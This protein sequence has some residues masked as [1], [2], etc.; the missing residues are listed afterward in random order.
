[1]LCNQYKSSVWMTYKQAND[2]GY[3]VKSKSKGI[4]C[5]FYST[6]E[7]KG[8]EAKQGEDKELIPFIKRFTLFNADQVEGYPVTE[9]EK[10]LVNFEENE[11]AQK[12]IGNAAKEIKFTYGAG[13]C[14]YLP[15]QDTICLPDREAFTSENT[16]YATCFHEIVHGTGN[17]KRLNRS[18]GGQYGS[19]EYAFE[20][21][22]AELGAAYLTSEIGALN[23]TIEGHAAYLQNWLG[24]LKSDKKAIFKA[25]AQAQK[26]SDF[27]LEKWAA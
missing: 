22:I 21:L 8:D 4:T 24:L 23:E 18:L 3:Q 17:S 25:A 16:F 11:L 9:I 14:C 7:K 10:N 6:Y 1:M 19:K 26:A 27:V 20:E 2:A 15:S 5:I 13:A 12:I